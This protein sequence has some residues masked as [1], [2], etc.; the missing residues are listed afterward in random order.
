[1]APGDRIA[2]GIM[3]DHVEVGPGLVLD[4]DAYLGYPS[5][6]AIAD[7]ALIIGRNARIRSGSVIY[8]GSR[9]GDDFETGHGTIVREEVAIGDGQVSAQALERG[10]HGR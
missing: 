2:P 8:A 1:L 3:G 10:D 7:P 4:P 6:R 9:I 5:G